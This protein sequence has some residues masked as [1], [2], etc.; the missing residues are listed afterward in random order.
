MFAFALWDGRRRTLLLAR[1][2]VGKKPLFYALKDGS[3]TFA[4]ELRALMEGRWINRE[5]ERV[6][7]DCFLAYG[8]DPP[9]V[10]IR[11]RQ[12]TAAR[13]LPSGA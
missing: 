13:S 8:Y 3:L 12:E 1:D 4:S 2:R 5:I 6:A 9:H 7:V 11:R 10:D